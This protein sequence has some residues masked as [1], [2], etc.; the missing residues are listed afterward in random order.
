M[1][2]LIANVDTTNDTF[3]QWIQKTNYIIQA[4]SNVAITTNSN[5][6]TGNASITGTFFANNLHSNNL[7]SIGN[8]NSNTLINQNTIV[9]SSSTSNVLISSV[10]MTING[11][12]AFHQDYVSMGNTIVSTGYIDTDTITANVEIKVGSTVIS[13]TNIF[14]NSINT[15]SLGVYSNASFGDSQAN[16]LVNRYGITISNNPLGTY[17]VNSYMTSTDLWIQNIHA[18]TL[19]LTGGGTFTFPSNTEFMG[20]NNYFDNGITTGGNTLIGGQLLTVTANTLFLGANNNFLLEFDLV[21]SNNII[22]SGMIKAG[23]GLFANTVT[24]YGLNNTYVNLVANNNAGNTTFTLPVADGT[25]NQVM[26]TDGNGN[27]SFISPFTGNATSDF[28]IRD[29]T[30]RS[31]GIGT[32]A[33]GVAGDLRAIGNITAYYSSDKRLKENIVNIPDALA[34]VV[35]LN[36]VTYDWTKEYIDNHGGIDGTFVRQ[37]NVG[38][39]AQEVQEVLPEIVVTKTDGYLGVRYEKLVA[40]LIEAIK[41]LKAEVDSLKNGH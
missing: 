22:A 23:K 33:S 10:G 34:K 38:V 7:V 40:L 31:I 30:A 9:I 15:F 41:E 14:A 37:R 35:A 11:L 8:G 20:T 32:S 1:T 21:E 36:G 12:T 19:N 5:T 25:A 18:N 4:M 6:A 17:T 29:I 39:I 27:L 24:V 13:N 3:G 28:I 2:V 16:T 26:V